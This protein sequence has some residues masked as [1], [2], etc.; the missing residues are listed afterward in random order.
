MSLKSTP[1]QPVPEGTARVAKAAFRRGNPL[2]KLR[3]ELG[4]I[5]RDE[6]F[7]DLF[8]RLG[9]PGLPPW[10]LALV[11]LLQ[12]REDLPDRQAAEA[13]RARI[14]WKYLLGLDLTDPGF[15]HSVLC[16]FRARLLGGGAE[17]RL[18]HKL[19][20][21]CQA[22]GLLKARG[23]QRTDATHVLASIRVL[24]RLELV[25]ETLRAA[26]NELATVAPDWLR[27]AVPRA[28]Y[29][30]YA[31][32][33]EGG[34]LPRS[35][36]E[37]EAYAR[38]VG[39]DGFALLDRLD[40]P[41]TA[42]ELRGLPKVATLRQVWARHFVREDG[43]APG[44]GA[45]LRAKDEPPP[46]GT[47]PVESPYDTEARYRT[48]S[49]TSVGY[50]V[51]LSETCEDDGV[52][53]ITH[54]MTTVATVHEARCTAAIHRALADK[55]LAPGEHLVDAAYVDAELLVRSHEDHGVDLVGPPRVNAS[56]QTKAEGGY[57][58]DRFEV[59][60]E[61]ER[62]R[63]PQGKLSS[64]WS[65]QVDHTGTPYVSVTF[66]RADCGACPAR[67]LCTRAAH[68]ARHLKLQ[69]RAEYGALEAARG[70]LATKEGRRCY[71]RRAGI[72]GT[73][74]QGVR[75]FGLRRS[76][77][78]GLAKTHLQHVATAAAVNLERLA[79]WFRAAP[80][81]A[82]RTSRFAGLA[83]A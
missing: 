50:V 15:D 12:F 54:A 56:W 23:R 79:A 5:F 25:G 35:A 76:R 21:V 17:E 36:A 41:E 8:P 42:A 10:R 58:I 13:V 27:A 44:G 74:S 61:R 43:A 28:W 67:A 37:R 45:R 78:R 63:C 81:A 73:I 34:R 72:E 26:L 39:E 18:L 3:D 82:T 51:H 62:V 59:D 32:R 22:R 33:V 77:Y 83:T 64:A 47:E 38:A 71:A 16:E 52:H 55:G 1:I 80:R 24:N 53:L 68:R 69:P 6:D 20:A 9:Q 66:R 60:W 65:R 46:P 49:G 11:T 14:D 29:E 7:A 75:A 70:R 19:L 4:G 48:R 40:R 2:L 57:T 30:R 31:L